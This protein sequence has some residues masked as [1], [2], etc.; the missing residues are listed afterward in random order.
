MKMK[1]ILNNCIYEIITNYKF[2]NIFVFGSE[3]LELEKFI[4]NHTSS[5]ITGGDVDFCNVLF[6]KYFSGCQNLELKEEINN[7]F[8]LNDNLNLN[9]F[10]KLA[11]SLLYKSYKPKAHTEHNLRIYNNIINNKDKL[12]EELTKQIHNTNLHLK[13]FKQCK[14]EIFFQYITNNDLLIIDNRKQNNINKKIIKIL[15]NLN[16]KFIVTSNKN[17]QDLYKFEI[18]KSK[19]FNVYSNINVKSK[20]FNYPSK[21]IS[22]KSFIAFNGKE[23]N[24]VKVKQLSLEQFNSLRQKYLSKQIHYLGVPKICYGL[25]TEDKLF[26]IIGITNDYKNKA[27]KEIEQPCVYLLSDFIINSNI[28]KLSKLVLYC[29][30]SKEVKLIAERLINKEVKSIY[31]NVFTKNMSS[32]KYRD[33]FVLQNRHQ[34]PDGNYNLTYYSLM[35]KWNLKEGLELW[36]QK[37]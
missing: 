6:G 37:L 35:G 5:P 14:I 31:T 33:L 23:I 20:L 30:L 15:N 11:L 26:G 24:D 22:Q 7:D 9:N 17:I 13:D 18:L 10:D 2:N 21:N 25:F 8:K 32:I 36:K 16:I 4:Y 29:V 1:N 12:I 34:L 3:N 27:P 19:N 28:K